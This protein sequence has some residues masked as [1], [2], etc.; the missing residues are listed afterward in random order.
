MMI[1]FKAWP[2]G[3]Y[4]DFK[5][6]YLKNVKVPIGGILGLD[7]YTYAMKN[8][9]CGDHEGPWHEGGRL[10]GDDEDLAPDAEDLAPDDE[11][12]GGSVATADLD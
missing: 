12:R 11:L 10:R 5:A 1:R 3:R 6:K 7:D 8:G 9:P 4:L 2:E